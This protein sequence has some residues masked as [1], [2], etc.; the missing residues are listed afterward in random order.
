[1]AEEKNKS[2]SCETYDP[3]EQ[4]LALREPIRYKL[5]SALKSPRTITEVAEILGVDRKTLYYH[6]KVLLEVGLVE[7][8]ESH[9]V[10]GCIETVYIKR[11]F[12]FDADQPED[13]ATIKE[14][15]LLGLQMMQD[16]YE[17]F[18]RMVSKEPHVKGGFNREQI[19]VKSENTESFKVIIGEILSETWA[20]IGELGDDDGDV[21]FTVA[22]QFFEYEPDSD[23]EE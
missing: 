13:L 22:N 20:R 21:V 6:L 16:L 7:K 15:R 3:G 18:M 11:G 12:Y 9:Q 23:P 2:I 14:L 4:L 19:R 17:D 10:R 1:M 5:F 8:V